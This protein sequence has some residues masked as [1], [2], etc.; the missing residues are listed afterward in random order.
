MKK[1]LVLDTH[2][3]AHAYFGNCFSKDLA[4]NKNKNKYKILTMI[5]FCFLAMIV[6]W[7]LFWDPIFLKK[8]PAWTNQHLSNLAF[9][10]PFFHCAEFMLFY[11]CILLSPGL[12]SFFVLVVVSLCIIYLLPSG[13]WKKKELQ[14]EWVKHAWEMSVR[15]S[16]LNSFL[17]KVLENYF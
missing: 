9:A 12:F 10:S 15:C 3:H 7:G 6:N 2:I 13:V 11:Y 4:Q 17:K 16:K 1:Q 14:I 5:L 8:R